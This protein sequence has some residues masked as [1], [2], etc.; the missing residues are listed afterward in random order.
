ME[1]DLVSKGSGKRVKGKGKDLRGKGKG[2]QQTEGGN[3]GHGKG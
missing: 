3:N 2:K 1:I